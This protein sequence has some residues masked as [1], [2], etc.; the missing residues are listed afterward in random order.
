MSDILVQVYAA[1]CKLAFFARCA[2]EFH[3]REETETPSFK[4]KHGKRGGG[5]R[6]NNRQPWNVAATRRDAHRKNIYQN[7]CWNFT[8]EHF[9]CTSYFT[10]R[11]RTK[12]GSGRIFTNAST[13]RLGEEF[14][15]DTSLHVA[16]S[17][18]NFNSRFANSRFFARAS[19]FDV[20]STDLVHLP[21]IFT[22]RRRFSIHPTISFISSGMHPRRCR[23]LEC[24]SIVLQRNGK[25]RRLPSPFPSSIEFLVRGDGH[26]RTE[27]IPPVSSYPSRG[28]GRN[29]GRQTKGEARELKRIRTV[30]SRWLYCYTARIPRKRE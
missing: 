25:N 27:T 10:I 24:R 3:V 14:S 21:S 13:G 22:T 28:E 2:V 7:C 26:R 1:N 5:E 15:A 4:E 8:R 29:G 17:R 16:P 30:D 12:G 9:A 20:S 19:A 23:L 11:C 6:K 18:R